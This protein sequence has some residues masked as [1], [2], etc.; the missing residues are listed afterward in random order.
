MACWSSALDAAR[1][2]I[3][4]NFPEGRTGFRFNGLLGLLS[5]HVDHWCE[6][7]FLSLLMFAVVC[8]ICSICIAAVKAGSLSES[9]TH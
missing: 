9:E 8:M 6:L 7:P 5:I 4:G 3:T 1:A 2:A